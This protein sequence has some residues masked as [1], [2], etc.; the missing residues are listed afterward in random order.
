LPWPPALAGLRGI[1]AFHHLFRPA[2]EPRITAYAAGLFAF[3]QTLNLTAIA[4]ATGWR[5]R[6]GFEEG[7]R[8]TFGEE[9]RCA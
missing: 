2:V 7:L 9:R 4:A 1:E 6:I 3:T 5:P 8:R